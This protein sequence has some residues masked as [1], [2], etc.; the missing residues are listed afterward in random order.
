[1]QMS[2]IEK[3]YGVFSFQSLSLQQA[4]ILHI[5]IQATR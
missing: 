2:V 3:K 5:L 1:M 4:A